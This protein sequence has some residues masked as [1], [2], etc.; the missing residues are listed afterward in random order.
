VQRA[1]TAVFLSCLTALLSPQIMYTEPAMT[2][3]T[4]TTDFGE[5]D[6]FVGTMKGVIWNIAP[7]AQIADITHAVPPQDI[8]TGAIALWRAAPFFPNGTVHIAVVD[9]GV[10]THRRPMAAR[11]GAQ[12]FVGPDNGL[13]T[14]MILDAR[15]AG[16]E[17]IFVQ[18]DKP[19]YWLRDVR[20]TFHGRD[21]FSPVA[22][23]LAV[24]VRLEKLGT[25][26]VDPVMIDIPQPEKLTNGWRAHISVIDAFGNLTTDLPASSLEHLDGLRVRIAGHEIDGLVASYGHRTPGDLVALV[27]SEGYVEVAVVN[28][29][30][31]RALHAKLGDPVEVVYPR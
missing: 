23:H 20:Y 31:A 28:G 1:K 25:P 11:I 2:V 12:Y 3:I 9:P 8:L 15:K 5:K 18:L 7:N 16:Q 6:G 27:D 26:F 24:G 4:I 17:M 30:A 22:A 21:I 13:F 29:N 19:E 14:P 10:G